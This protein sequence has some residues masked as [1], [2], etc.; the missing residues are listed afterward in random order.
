MHENQRRSTSGSPHAWNPHRVGFF[1]VMLVLG[2]VL[3]LILYLHGASWWF[4]PLAAPGA[5][6]AHVAIF[7]GI[8]LIA[9]R[10]GRRRGVG[11]MQGHEGEGLQLHNPR[12][13]DGLAS[14]ITLHRDKDLRRWTL[15]QADLE[16][17]D[18]VLDVGS[19]TGTLLLAAAERVGPSGTL[20]GIEPSTEMAAH[21]LRKAKARRIPLEIVD[22]SADR[23]PHPPASFDAVLCTLVFHHLPQQM[24]APAVR[25]MY[26]VLRPGGH[27]VIVDWQRPRSVA[28]AIVSPMFLVYLLHNLRPGGSA[29]DEPSVEALMKELGFKEVSRRSFGNGGPVGAVVGRLAAIARTADPVG[30]PEMGQIPSHA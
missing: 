10:L 11:H 5:V 14:L 20:Q 19:G 16:P 15:D 22:G 4:A 27:V 29:L 28:R 6:L 1:A 7:G 8:A 18:A 24:R 13:F 12:L 2:G 3:A 23:L 9:A 21:A 17:G 25:E 26:R 30:P